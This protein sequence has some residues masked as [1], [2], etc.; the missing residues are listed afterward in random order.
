L[1]AVPERRE[2]DASEPGQGLWPDVRR[3]LRGIS[4]K[5]TLHGAVEYQVRKAGRKGIVW[6]A[7]DDLPDVVVKAF[8]VQRGDEAE[9]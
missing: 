5:R 8:A 6:V 9:A 4:S 2:I 1:K 7:S 3:V